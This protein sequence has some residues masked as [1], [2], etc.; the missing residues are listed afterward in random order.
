MKL[1]NQKYAEMNDVQYGSCLIR[2]AAECRR[3]AEAEYRP[4]RRQ[5]DT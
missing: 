3:V 1:A 2:T 4:S 5:C